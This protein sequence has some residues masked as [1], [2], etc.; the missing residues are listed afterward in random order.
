MARVLSS[1]VRPAFIRFIVECVEVKILRVV[2]HDV[3]PGHELL[4][5]RSSQDPSGDEDGFSAGVILKG[6]ET[7]LI[8]VNNHGAEGRG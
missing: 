8:S 2:P 5:F 4:E 7:H 6:V 3:E 1:S